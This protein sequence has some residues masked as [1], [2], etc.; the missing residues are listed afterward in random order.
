MA[1]QQHR[2]RSIEYVCAECGREVGRPNLLRK[3][4]E[5]RELGESGRLVKSRTVAWLCRI[6]QEDG[7]LSCVDKDP[8]YNRHYF[9][10]APGMADTDMARERVSK[11]A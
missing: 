8:D 2:T 9:A 1:E 10:D 5:F 11:S 3:K 7:T 6:P 4:V